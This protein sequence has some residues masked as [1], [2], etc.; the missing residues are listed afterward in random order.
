M[1]N[2]SLKA[3]R[4]NGGCSVWYDSFVVGSIAVLRLN[5]CAK[6]PP[7][8]LDL[9]PNIFLKVTTIMKEGLGVL[10]TPIMFIN[11]KQLEG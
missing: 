7:Q 9:R 1:S 6:N 10:I 5:I 4:R 3:V 11:L 8:P 2:D